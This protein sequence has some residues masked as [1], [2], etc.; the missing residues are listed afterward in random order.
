MG[1]GGGMR[2]PIRQAALAFVI[3]VLSVSVAASAK[4]VFII[5]DP[6]IRLNDIP[7]VE[8]IEYVPL[9]GIIANSCDV[10]IRSM[11]DAIAAG[12]DAIVTRSV[13]DSEIIVHR[14]TARYPDIVVIEV[15]VVDEVVNA[16]ANLFQIGASR[17]TLMQLSEG[18]A[19]RV[20]T[21]FNL[22][23][24][25]RPQFWYSCK[26]AIEGATQT[27]SF[28]YAAPVDGLS[29][30]IV[31]GSQVAGSVLL[32]NSSRTIGTVLGD[33]TYSYGG[34][35]E[36]ALLY[37]ISVDQIGS[38]DMF[39]HGQRLENF[40]MDFCPDCGGGTKLCGTPCP[41]DCNGSCTQEGNQM[42]CTKSGMPR[43]MN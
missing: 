41:K 25:P 13:C 8:G 39:D 36:L 42:C 16:S 22:S 31:A 6:S 18:L 24:L 33:I 12:A 34:R 30:L 37:V 17:D 15:G 38:R 7:V 11:E 23:Q 29:S 3:L 4:Q 5:A 21:D 19:K 27:G 40:L 43:P 10:Q 26:D 32:N 35:G 1:E 2:A 28:C 14:V 20:E 9:T